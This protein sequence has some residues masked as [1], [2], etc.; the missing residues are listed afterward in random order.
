MFYSEEE[1]KQQQVSPFFPSIDSAYVIVEYLGNLM[2]NSSHFC[3]F[4]QHDAGADESVFLGFKVWSSRKLGSCA[5]L[6]IILSCYKGG[7]AVCLRVAV[8]GSLKRGFKCG[9]RFWFF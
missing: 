7:G 9:L 1:N 8:S 5:I 2:S 4:D 3:Q 6:Q